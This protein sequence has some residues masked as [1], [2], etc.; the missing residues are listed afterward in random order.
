M[1]D[2]AQTVTPIPIQG[3]LHSPPALP[4]PST[5][6]TPVVGTVS[7][8]IGTGEN[9]QHA[10]VYRTILWSFIAGGVLS[11]ATVGFSIFKGEQPPLVAVR[12]I[13]AIFA[14]LIT[15]ALGYLFGKGK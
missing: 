13:W 6:L 5:Q 14:P 1:A 2:S 4:A 11:S 7:L 10:I 15:L 12:D 8:Q 3:E 9:A